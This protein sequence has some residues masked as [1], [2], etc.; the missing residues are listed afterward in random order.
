MEVLIQH[1][2]TQKFLKAIGIW[3]NE[4]NDAL[5]FKS[6][7]NAMQFGE[8][9]KLKDVQLVVRFQKDKSIAIRGKR[10]S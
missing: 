1:Q 4:P 5:F 8:G 6:T 7:A 10:S 3:T 9:S 2:R